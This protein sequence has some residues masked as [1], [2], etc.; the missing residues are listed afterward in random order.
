MTEMFPHGVRVSVG[1]GLAY[2]L[3]GGTAPAVATW[4]SN[5]TGNN[6]GFAW[7]DSRLSRSCWLWPVNRSHLPLCGRRRRCAAT[8][9]H[10][11]ACRRSRTSPDIALQPPHRLLPRLLS[12]ILRPVARRCNCPALRQAAIDV[13]RAAAS[14]SA[15]M[16]P[17]MA[18]LATG[19]PCSPQP[20]FSRGSA[21]EHR[22]SAPS[23]SRACWLSSM[24]EGTRIEVRETPVDCR[25]LGSRLLR[26][27]GSDDVAI[28]TFDPS[29]RDRARRA[30]PP[31]AAYSSSRAAAS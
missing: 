5:Q 8:V 7:W 15:R 3:F 19:C 4:L 2:A 27:L 16:R 17:C 24:Y 22:P 31:I 13:R 1:H 6:T 9:C 29:S 11:P 10:R 23:R 30:R 26:A 18:T 12:F 28:T 21:V 25:R 14:A 20:R